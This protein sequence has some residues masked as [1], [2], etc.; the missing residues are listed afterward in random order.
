MLHGRLGMLGQ[1][2]LADMAGKHRFGFGCACE[3]GKQGAMPTSGFDRISKRIGTG[4]HIFT[5]LITNVIHQ[6]WPFTG[7]TALTHSGNDIGQHL[8]IG[9]AISGHISGLI[10]IKTQTAWF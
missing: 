8:C 2:Q 9:F 7:G 6:L 4:N 3:A 5:R 10:G 1:I